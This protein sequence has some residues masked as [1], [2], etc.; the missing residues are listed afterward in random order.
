M[1]FELQPYE[2]AGALRFGMSVFEA[3]SFLGSPKSIFHTM[4]FAGESREYETATLGF[5][6]LGQ[7]VHIGFC[8]RD[9]VQL[10]CKDVDVFGASAALQELARLDGKPFTFVGFVYLLELGLQLGGFHQSAD[11]GKTVSMFE[12]GRYDIKLLKF[13]PLVLA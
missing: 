13:K 3:E 9:P 12:R 1:T 5:N 4:T 11:E 7:L 2:G 10:V 8:E 6:S